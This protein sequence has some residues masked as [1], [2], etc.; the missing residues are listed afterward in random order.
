LI[1]GKVLAKKGYWA[2]ASAPQKYGIKNEL[3]QDKVVLSKTVLSKIR[4]G[5]RYAPTS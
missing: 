1:A 4:T 3:Y 5:M 2:N